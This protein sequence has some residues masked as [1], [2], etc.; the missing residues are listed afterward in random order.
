MN[1]VIQ[2]RK[3]YAR[4]CIG[5]YSDQLTYVNDKFRCI[6]LVDKLNSTFLSRFEKE[7]VT[8]D[9]LLNPQQLKSS[10]NIINEIKLRQIIEEATKNYKINYNIKDLLINWGKENI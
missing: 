8:F 5:N 1:Y 4:I 3:K 7:I 10:K 9:K 6:I 2:D